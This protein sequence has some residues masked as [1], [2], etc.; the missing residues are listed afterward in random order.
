MVFSRLG[1][2][3]IIIVNGAVVLVRVI[4]V[5]LLVI[6][7]LVLLAVVIFLVLSSLSIFSKIDMRSAPYNLR[8]HLY[9]NSL[10]LL[11]RIVHHYI[12]FLHQVSSCKSYFDCDCWVIN[13]QLL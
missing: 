1:S 9:D 2:S 7:L 6:I 10:C 11:L 4:M 5:G 8:V 12:A 13:N 3:S